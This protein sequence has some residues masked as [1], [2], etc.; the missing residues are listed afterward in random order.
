MARLSR[1]G[2]NE[3]KRKPV[4]KRKTAKE[5]RQLRDDDRRRELDLRMAK[6][7]IDEAFSRDPS[8]IIR[9]ACP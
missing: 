7:K 1:L 2:G 8:T 5:D 4:P 3:M 6:A 9:E